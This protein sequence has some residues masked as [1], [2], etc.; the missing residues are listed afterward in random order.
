MNDRDIETVLQELNRR[1]ITLTP[2]LM[3]YWAERIADEVE[4][5]LTA[6]R[7]ETTPKPVD[8]WQ[9]WSEKDVTCHD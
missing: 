2:E 8:V 1:T 7:S 4:K 3:D 9:P 5:R 6:K